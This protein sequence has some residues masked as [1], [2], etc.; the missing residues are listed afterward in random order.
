M[1]IYICIYERNV[2]CASVHFS[3]TAEFVRISDYRR[4][5]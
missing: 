2:E 5:M 3:I 1:F 4:Y